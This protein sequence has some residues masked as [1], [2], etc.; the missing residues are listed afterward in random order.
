MGQW[1]GIISRCFI[2][3]IHALVIPGFISVSVTFTLFTIRIKTVHFRSQRILLSVDWPALLTQHRDA[4]IQPKASIDFLMNW[5]LTIL[6]L[7]SFSRVYISCSSWKTFASWPPFSFRF[8]RTACMPRSFALSTTTNNTNS[9]KLNT[10]ATRI[11]DTKNNWA[12]IV[13]EVWLWK[14]Q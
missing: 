1:N 10:K 3:Y 8:I 13:I 2:K 11:A 5:S 4:A 6:K 12:I 14:S 7:N 9:V